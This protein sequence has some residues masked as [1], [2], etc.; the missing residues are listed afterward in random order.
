L[1]FLTHSVYTAR[2]RGDNH[3]TPPPI[4]DF[5]DQLARA[6]RRPFLTYLRHYV[7]QHSTVDGAYWSADHFITRATLCQRGTIAMDPCLSVRPSVCHKP[8]F[9]VISGQIE[10]VF[11]HGGCLSSTPHRRSGRSFYHAN[12]PPEGG[13][14]VMSRDSKWRESIMD[15][16]VEL[17]AF[18]RPPPPRE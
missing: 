3:K 8:V 9:A 16:W 2:G 15:F 4:G 6:A 18:I 10:L 7:G 12:C 11:R 13:T 17:E 14:V 5:A 1:F